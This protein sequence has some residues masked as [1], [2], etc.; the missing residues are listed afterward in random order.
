VT[1]P[2]GGGSPAVYRSRRISARAS[3]RLAR[4]FGDKVPSRSK[5]SQIAMARP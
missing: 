5:S 4:D 2:A 3:S 1:I